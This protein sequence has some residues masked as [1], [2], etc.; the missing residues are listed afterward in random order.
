[1]T[2]LP[3]PEPEGLAPAALA[4]PPALTVADFTALPENTDRGYELQEGALVMSAKPPAPHQRGVGRLFSQLD[5]QAPAECAVVL[6]VSVDLELVEARQPGTVRAPDLVV[7]TAAAYDRVCGEG[8]IFRAAEVLLAVEIKS[9]STQR[10]DSIVKHSEYA[11][12]GIGHYWITDLTDGPSLTAAHLGGEFGY[13][14]AEPVKGVFETDTPFP[15]RVDL[16]NL[17]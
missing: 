2:A 3:Q 1:M 9:P 7:T 6:D 14:D 11:D 8:G 13:V 16:T 10:T 15:A 12:A 5:A 4:R 17:V